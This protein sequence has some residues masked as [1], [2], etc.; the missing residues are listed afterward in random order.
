MH[1]AAESYP[2]DPENQD[3]QNRE[4]HN[5]ENYGEHVHGQMLLGRVGAPIRAVPRIGW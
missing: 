2:I 3:V 5:R 1:R 4:C